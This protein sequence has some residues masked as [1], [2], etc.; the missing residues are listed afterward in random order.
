MYELFL[1]V[2]A[3]VVPCLLY[4]ILAVFLFLAWK[5]LIEEA[6]NEYN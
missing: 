1:E 4:F 2:L 5:P 3:K 6:W